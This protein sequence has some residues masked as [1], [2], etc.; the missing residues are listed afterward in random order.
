MNL[1]LPAK[2]QTRVLLDVD[3]FFNRSNFNDLAEEGNDDSFAKR[4]RDQI[5]QAVEKWAY[6]TGHA[7]YVIGD[8]EI[9]KDPVTDDDIHVR[10][11]LELLFWTMDFPE[12]DVID[13]VDP[14][15]RRKRDQIVDAIT[16]WQYVIG[17]GGFSVSI[18][19]GIVQHQN[20]DDDFYVHDEQVNCSEDH[21][22]VEDANYSA[23]PSEQVVDM[24]P[25]TKAETNHGVPKTDN[26]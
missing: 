22:D 3:M 14:F 2:K 13:G 25:V 23:L 24:K 7:G 17:H 15:A 6:V 16:K 18:V 4:K 5:S 21:H 10:Y 20:R 1:T 9:T 8:Y 19:G 12:L 26:E 11:D